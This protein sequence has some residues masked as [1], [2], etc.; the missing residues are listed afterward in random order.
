MYDDS[1]WDEYLRAIYEVG[2]KKE[3]K[4]DKKKMK[5]IQKT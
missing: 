5:E 3:R 1:I 4:K 2:K